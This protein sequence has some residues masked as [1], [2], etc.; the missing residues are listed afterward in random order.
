[1]TATFRIN[2]PGITGG[3]PATGDW[4]KARADLDLFALGGTVEFEAQDSMS[5]YSW[6]LVSEMDGSSI[7]LST[8][9]AQTAGADVT[10]TGG[11]IIRLTVDDGLP[12]KDIQERYFGV[13]L[14]G[15]NL[16]IPA[17]YETI[18]DN[19][20]TNYPGWE[21][22]M[23][24]WMKYIDASVAGGGGVFEEPAGP[25]LSTLR[26]GSGGT[27]AGNYSMSAGA[28]NTIDV[29]SHYCFV[30]GGYTNASWANEVVNSTYSLVMGYNNTLTNGGYSFVFGRYSAVWG[31]YGFCFGDFNIVGDV[32]N[33]RD[34]VL[35]LGKDN[36]IDASGVTAI[37]QKN[38]CGLNSRNAAVLGH[39]NRAIWPGVLQHSMAEFSAYGLGQLM[40]VHMS[41]ATGDDSWN[42]LVISGGGPIS[43]LELQ[44]Q[45]I[46]M[47]ELRLIARTPD[48]T[49]LPS[50]FKTWLVR[51]TVHNDFDNNPT[52]YFTDKTIMS[53]TGGPDE[54]NWDVDVA[55]DGSSPP[56]TIDVTVKGAPLN[57]TRWYGVLTVIYYEDYDTSPPV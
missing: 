28:I 56:S 39:Y 44:N 34:D 24:A 3:K 29:N 27:V 52:L 5:S 20:D 25:T 45:T 11:Y 31:N 57:T 9:T 18:Q 48:S 36:T 17:P 41:A 51:F 4:G 49:G 43:E 32:S 55:V 42:P 47:C 33:D 7:T 12:T 2:Q 16:P 30:Y 15:S 38:I 54:A 1:M 37:G 35:V 22:K 40:F 8:P 21:R 53:T 6:E 23:T 10:V 13:P 46:Y 14:A 50:F 26:T 19:R